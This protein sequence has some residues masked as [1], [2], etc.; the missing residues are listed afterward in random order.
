MPG[1]VSAVYLGVA[2]ELT[3]G[4][5]VI[6]K[7][8][9]NYH[10]KE[11]KEFDI[12]NSF[13]GKAVL[14]VFEGKQDVGCYRDLDDAFYEIRNM[15]RDLCIFGLE[16]Y[17]FDRYS[18]D[19]RKAEMEEIVIREAKRYYDRAKEI[20]AKNRLFIAAIQVALVEKRVLTQ[21]DIKAIREGIV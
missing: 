5:T 4:F 17:L 6:K 13:G 12:L 20:I 10:T 14:E 7:N 18:S 19:K 11:M 9:C 16:G 15:V 3:R 2:D 1:S 21:R 8:D